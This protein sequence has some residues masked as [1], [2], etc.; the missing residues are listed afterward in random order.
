MSQRLS[1][2]LLVL[3]VIWA[4]SEYSLLTNLQ[5]FILLM[6]VWRMECLQKRLRR[7]LVGAKR[8]ALRSSVSLPFADEDCSLEILT[9]K[10]HPL[11]I[12]CL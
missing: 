4:L 12:P 2:I 8:K 10:L 9:I 11:V 3:I 1:S 7:N 5:N 6:I